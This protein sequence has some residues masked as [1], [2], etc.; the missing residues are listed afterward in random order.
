MP[1][2]SAQSDSDE[3]ESTSD[4]LITKKERRTYIGLVDYALKVD[5]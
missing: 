2:L 4:N 5:T 1:A 3:A